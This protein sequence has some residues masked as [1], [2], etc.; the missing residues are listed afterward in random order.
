MCVNQLLELDDVAKYGR[1]SE[2]WRYEI[3]DGENRIELTVPQQSGYVL[4]DPFIKQVDK[5]RDNNYR[6]L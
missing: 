6:A 1:Q 4:L 2:R 3:E 5:N